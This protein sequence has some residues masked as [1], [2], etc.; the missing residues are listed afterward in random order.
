M[1]Y[2]PISE[3]ILPSQ[4]YYASTKADLEVLMA[5]YCFEITNFRPPVK[6]ELFLVSHAGEFSAAGPV[7]YAGSDM[8]SSSPRYIVKKIVTPKQDINTLWE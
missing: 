8:E 5:Y 4:V 3:P 7:T 1:K 2:Q 6:G